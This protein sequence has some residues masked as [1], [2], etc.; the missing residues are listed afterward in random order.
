MPDDSGNHDL[1]NPL[2][3]LAHALEPYTVQGPSPHDVA[4][5]AWF[6]KTFDRV[7]KRAE[8]G[9]A[10]PPINPQDIALVFIIMAQGTIF[11]IELPYFD[12]S[13]EDWLHLS[14][15]ALVKG[16]I[17]SNNMVAGLQTL[18]D[19]GRRGDNAW[20]LWGLVIRLIQAMGMH[21]DGDRWNLPRD[22][23]KERRKVFWECNAA[24][25]FQAHCFSRPSAINPEHCD[26][27]FPS[28]PLKP[29]GEKSYSIIWFELSQLSSE[30]LNMAMKVRKP[31]YS[32]VVDLD[33]RLYVSAHGTLCA[34]LGLKRYSGEFEHN[35]PFSLRCRA[36]LLATPSHYPQLETAIKAS[37]EPSRRSL[38]ISFQQT[39]L[40][41]N[42]S[43]T[44]INLHRPYYAKALYDVDRDESPYKSSFYT[45]I[46]RCGIIIAIV[47][48]I[49]ARFPAVSIRQWNFWHHVFNSSLC[50][51]TLVM[52]DPSNVLSS[53]V[54]A[55]I[56]A[57]ISLFTSLLQ[58]GGHTPRHKSNLQWLVNLRSRALSKISEASSS[59]RDDP[60]RDIDSDRRSDGGYRD[61][62]GEHEEDVEFL[63][64]R[65]R[66]IERAGQ[67][68]R[69]TSRT[70]R[71]V[72]SPTESLATD[73]AN[74]P[75]G[76]SCLQDQLGIPGM[77]IRS[78][79][80]P[81][82]PLDLTNDMLH[83]F[84]DPM[85]LQDVFG[86]AQDQQNPFVASATRWDDAADA[87]QARP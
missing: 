28:E 30:I 7:Y 8:G 87:F 59:Q 6:K 71:P 31:P 12:P 74:P 22:V 73:T 75:V 32:D 66:L 35:I 1:P 83:E 51:G 76:G 63:G 10:H 60:Q 49:H 67:C 50:L 37:P 58:H 48:D 45:V 19:K 80:L 13:V 61:R 42:V 82:G 56:D 24:D 5:K 85:L 21:R 18:L 36:A 38:A 14:E 72:E 3:I 23:A 4:P 69:K 27:A 64:W 29:N 70:I 9:H 81:A 65:T 46:E 11:N 44:I 78:E 34:K 16:D 39:N 26:T 43:E 55:Q 62:H 2:T 54:L 52:R 53:F 86:P 79:S 17:L 40:A 25:T 20:P 84:W 57:A 15:R 47:T 33:R 68:S 77:A 41:L